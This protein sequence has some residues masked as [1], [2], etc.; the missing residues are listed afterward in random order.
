MDINLLLW[1]GE[2]ESMDKHVYTL[3]HMHVCT[4]IYMYDSLHHFEKY[5][6]V[7]VYNGV[8]CWYVCTLISETPSLK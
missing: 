8:K 2:Q 5:H 7:T 1:E 6:D 4:H 3:I